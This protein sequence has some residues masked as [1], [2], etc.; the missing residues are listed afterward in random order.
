[1]RYLFIH[2][3]SL[4]FDAAWRKK[5]GWKKR[6]LWAQHRSSL[7]PF[8]FTA[9]LNNLLHLLLF[10]AW[11]LSHGIREPTTHPLDEWETNFRVSFLL[12]C[13]SKKKNF[14]VFLEKYNWVSFRWMPEASSRIPFLLHLKQNNKLTRDISIS[15]NNGRGWSD[16]HLIFS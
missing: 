13:F 12:L 16:R 1:M 5:N 4:D 2:Y 7:S 14:L 9:C 11:N 10:V 3:S 15:R 8:P 6:T